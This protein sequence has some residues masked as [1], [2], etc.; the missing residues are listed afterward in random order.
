[1]VVRFPDP[2]LGSPFCS[3][4]FRRRL[5][6]HVQRV[7]LSRPHSSSAKQR[8]QGADVTPL[9]SNDLAHVPFG[10]FQFDHVV[11]EMIDEDLIGFVDNPLRNLLNEHA[12]VGRCFSHEIDYATEAAGAA[13]GLEYS[14]PTRS[15][16]C[17][18]FDTQ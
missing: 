8:T 9:P 1:M 11:I 13:T 3:A 7:T 4:D 2:A 14:L 16:I 17:A 15:D 5:V 10:D 12:N 6:D 18:P